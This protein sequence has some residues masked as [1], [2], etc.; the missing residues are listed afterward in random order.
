M[1][2][3]KVG[4]NKPP[5]L[6][7]LEQVI[8]YLYKYPSDPFALSSFKDLQKTEA[9]KVDENKVK[10][11]QLFLEKHAKHAIC[12]AKIKRYPFHRY[13][14][15]DS[16]NNAFCIQADVKDG[17]LV[18]RPDDTPRDYRK[19]MLDFVVT[20]EGNI[21]L[22]MKHYWMC[23]EQTFVYASGRLIL[24]GSGGIEYIDNYSGHYPN[25][26]KQFIHSMR[27]FESVKIH[28]LKAWRF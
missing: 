15:L 21:L 10:D 20:K 27:F 14:I 8:E 23:E 28:H 24:N 5:A 7:N 16:L 19:I 26:E 25:D 2:V 22:G 17:K 9:D 11:C 18:T 12:L 3:L 6:L 13:E 1:G 4:V